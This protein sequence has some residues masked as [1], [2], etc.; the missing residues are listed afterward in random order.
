MGRRQRGQIV[1][2][3]LL[4]DKP[5]GI[6]SN[7]ALQRARGILNARKAGHTGSLDPFATGML[8]VCFGQATRFSQYL[9]DASKCYRAVAQLGQATE[10]GD[11]EGEVVER[12]PVGDFSDAE[13]AAVVTD[14]TGVIDQRPPMYSALKHEGKRLYEL[15]RA[16]IEVPRPTRQVTIHRLTARRLGADQLELEV[17]CSKGTYIRTL[18]ED[19]ARALG[20]VAF[21]AELR[22]LWVGPFAER[23]ML[24]LEALEAQPQTERLL[25]VDFPLRWMPRVSLSPQEATVVRHGQPLTGRLTIEPADG[26][27]ALDGGEADRLIRLYA[28]EEFLGLARQTPAGLAPAKI[29]PVSERP[30]SEP[31]AAAPAEDRSS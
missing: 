27:T 19:L 12:Q 30:I 1:D 17:H 23:P 29:L 28:G 25:P 4:L 11:P 8:P 18:V 15:A 26:N 9:L 5:A 31:G 7:R 16:G 10:T 13:L 2:G 6:S 24:T 21:C 22:R 3:I 14:L 20:T